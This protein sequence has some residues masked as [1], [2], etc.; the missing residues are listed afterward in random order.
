MNPITGSRAVQYYEGDIPAADRG[1]PF[2][3]DPKAYVSL[4]ALLF[5]GL[6]SE[7][8]RVQEGKCLN[9]AV[10]SDPERLL[11]VFAALLAAASPCKEPAE[12]FRVERADDFAA[13]AEARETRSFTSTCRDGFLPAYGDKRGIVLLHWTLPAGT[14]C[15]IL[16][17]LLAD[18]GKADEN[19]LLLPPFLPFSCSRRPLTAAESAVTDCEGRPPL[20]ACELRLSGQYAPAP[21]APR[22]GAPPASAPALWE[23]LNAGAEPDAETVSAYLAWKEALHR[24]LRGIAGRQAAKTR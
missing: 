5:A 21:A 13:Y 23:Q 8:L 1:D 16:A 12:G 4:N 18:Y 17:E 24:W 20:Y 11:D 19:E 9:P 10:F 6:R 2:W 22:P 15:I 14:P 7:R 3:G